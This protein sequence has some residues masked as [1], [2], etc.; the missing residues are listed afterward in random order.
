MSSV[1]QDVYHILNI[2][3][4]NWYNIYQHLF[5]LNI[6]EYFHQIYNH[7]H[8]VYLLHL[9]TIALVH[10]CLFHM[11]VNLPLFLQDYLIFQNS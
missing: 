7:N 6:Y 2:I 9:E 3:Q 4:T 8:K 5:R 1:Q 11:L 10:L